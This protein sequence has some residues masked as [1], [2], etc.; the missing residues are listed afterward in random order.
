M[1]TAI[2]AAS[3]WLTLLGAIAFSQSVT[4]DYD[5]TANFPAYKSYA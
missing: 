2:L 4:F 5:H 3:A 1:R